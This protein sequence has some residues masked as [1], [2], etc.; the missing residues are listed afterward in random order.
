[1]DGCILTG[2]NVIRGDNDSIKNL[3]EIFDGLLEYLKEEIIE[4]SHN[5]GSQLYCHFPFLF[6]FIVVTISDN[7]AKVS[8]SLHYIS[9]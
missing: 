9:K 8:G 4:E 5:G 3:L 2:E 6:F 1:M 7:R